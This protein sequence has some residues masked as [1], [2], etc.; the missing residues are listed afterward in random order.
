MKMGYRAGGHI[1]TKSTLVETYRYKYG[2][3]ADLEGG[4][5]ESMVLTPYQNVAGVRY[6]DFYII[7]VLNIKSLLPKSLFVTNSTS[8]FENA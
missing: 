4:E 8:S 5:E 6:I 3:S 1:K 2:T 7:L